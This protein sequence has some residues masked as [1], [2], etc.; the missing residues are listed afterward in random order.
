MTGPCSGL[1]KKGPEHVGQS[2][3]CIMGPIISFLRPH[4]YKEKWTGPIFSL[5]WS[6]AASLGPNLRKRL[7]VQ[8]HTYGHPLSFLF[9]FKGDHKV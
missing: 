2:S 3:L 7:P 6:L 4:D 8:V 9:L 5:V 1:Q